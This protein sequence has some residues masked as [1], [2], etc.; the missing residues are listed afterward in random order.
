MT[1]VFLELKHTPGVCFFVH[2]LLLI[3]GYKMFLSV[4]SR[5]VI[6][7]FAWIRMLLIH[8]FVTMILVLQRYLNVQP[9]LKNFQVFSAISDIVHFSFLRAKFANDLTWSKGTAT[10]LKKDSN[11]SAFL[12]NTVKFFKTPILKNNCERLLLHGV[13]LKSWPL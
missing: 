6:L 7:S 8:L 9:C 13:C 3:H 1:Y 5:I 12:V 4:L 2:Y 10:L 11:T